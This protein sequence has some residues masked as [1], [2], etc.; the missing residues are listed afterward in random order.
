MS[1]HLFATKS[2]LMV[3]LSD[4][5]ALGLG[6]QRPRAAGRRER[7]AG[8]PA[9]V[10]VV[11]SEDPASPGKCWAGVAIKDRAVATSGDYLRRFMTMVVGTA[12]SFIPRTGY[13]VANGRRAGSVIAP[14]RTVAGIL[15]P[16]AFILGPS[17]GLKLVG[18][19]IWG[20]R[21]CPH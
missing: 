11:G 2:A 5:R 20:Q 15:S 7:P 16:T 9:W 12:T 18:N 3:A 6:Q 4:V 10:W 1:S 19:H 13:S 17:E 8:K 14:S 21:V